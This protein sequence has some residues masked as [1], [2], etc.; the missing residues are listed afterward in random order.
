MPIHALLGSNQ[1]AAPRGKYHTSYKKTFE[2]GGH[3]VPDG[4]PAST[5]MF[6]QGNAFG[7]KGPIRSL[8]SLDRQ[9]W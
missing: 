5:Q 9:L 4:Y 8:I 6:L 7:R 1:V 2:P 3:G